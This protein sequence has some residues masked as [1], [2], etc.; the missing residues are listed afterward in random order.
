MASIIT[1]DFTDALYQSILSL[2][3]VFSR[4][5]LEFA[6]FTYHGAYGLCVPS[7]TLRSAVCYGLGSLL[8]FVVVVG[9]LPIWIGARMLIRAHEGF[10]MGLG[11]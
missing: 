2:F 10:A 3:F 1:I 11:Y 6:D 9:V 4:D 5:L 8:A 7:W